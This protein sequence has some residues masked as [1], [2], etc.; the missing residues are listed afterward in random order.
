[1]TIESWLV[2]GILLAAVVLFVTERLRVDVVALGVVVALMLTGI[3]STPEALAGFSNAAVLTIASL[4][5]VGGAVTRTGLAGEIGRRLLVIGGRDERRLTIVLMLSVAL[6]SSFM[7][8][9]GTVAVLLPGVIALAR[10]SEI[11]PSRLLIPLSFGAL[12]GGATTLIGTP[13][14]IIITDLLRQQGLE[15]FRFF[16]FTPLGFLLVGAGISFM[17]LAGRRLL[18]ERKPDVE[19]QRVETPR[20]LIDLYRIPENMY[21]LRVRRSSALVGQTLA[22]ARLREDHRITVIELRRPTEPQLALSLEDLAGHGNQAHPVQESFRPDAQTSIEPG[23]VLIVQGEADDVR[24]ASAVWNLGV[25]PS[26]PADQAALVSE[27]IG[28]AEVLLPPRSS[29]IGRT[30]VQSRF[31]ATYGLSVLGILR[32]G[33]RAPLDLKATPLQFG[34]ILLTQG[35]WQNILSLK[36]RPRDFVVIGQPEAMIEVTRRDKAPLAL[37]ILAGALVLMIANWASVATTSMLAALAMVLTGCL[38]MDEAYQAVDWR[39]VV[40]IAGM[41]PMSTAL[42]KVA[43]VDLAANALTSGLGDLGP[44]AVLA[45]LLLLTSSLTQVL[46]NTATT[47]LIAPIALASAQSLDLRPQAF[48]MAVAI[49]ASMAFAA[50]VASPVNTLVMGAG[51][52]RFSD[53]L[54]VGL[55]MTLLVLLLSLLALPALFPFN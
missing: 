21:R 32:A 1:M 47:V 15:A 52:Y 42:E 39:S 18:P 49:G 51:G 48:L 5:V 29:L 11:S 14:N 45:G 50:P 40:L 4:F 28:I 20:E 19:T 46:S 34:D 10:S 22:S 6:L 8:D 37:L 31:G 9:T 41:I 38:T 13:P 36:H 26:Q 44:L 23:D 30:L 25:Q 12:L 17:L 53:Y 2:L 3:L 27:E 54:R 43:F 24:H 7:S 35:T 33:A 55:P 16:S